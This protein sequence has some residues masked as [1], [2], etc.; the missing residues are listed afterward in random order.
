MNT[1]LV[2]SLTS[3]NLLPLDTARVRLRSLKCSTITSA[4]LLQE[5]AQRGGYRYRVAMLTL[6]Y[7]SMDGYAPRHLSDLLMHCRKYCK[8]KGFTFRYVWVM[9]LQKRGAPHYHVLI[10]M[11]SGM[12]LPMPDRQGWWNHGS[13]R[14]EWA[15][16][17]V[18]YIAGYVGKATNVFE[19]PFGARIYGSGGLDCRA[20]VEARWWKLPLW[21]RKRWDLITD[22][23]RVAG[24]FVKVSTGEFAPTPWE[25]VFLEG[26]YYLKRKNEHDCKRD[27]GNFQHG[28]QG[29]EWYEHERWQSVVDPFTGIIFQTRGTRNENGSNP[30]GGWTE[31]VPGR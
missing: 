11:P 5:Q 15:K 21:A 23:K 17:A 30:F 10:W 28:C 4:R 25:V 1:G 7:G 13:T 6:T 19:F 29:V 27:S 3:G 24:G 8:R 20:L 9:E 14:I 22:V 12:R 2:Y 16:N 26:R 18:G 31:G